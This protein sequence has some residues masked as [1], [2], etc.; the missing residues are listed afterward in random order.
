MLNQI[1]YCKFVSEMLSIT[2]GLGDPGFRG[3]GK[4][5]M[6]DLIDHTGTGGTEGGI[7]QADEFSDDSNASDLD[8]SSSEENIFPNEHDSDKGKRNQ[9]HSRKDSKSSPKISVNSALK[10][11]QKLFLMMKDK[12]KRQKIPSHLERLLTPFTADKLVKADPFHKQNDG[13]SDEDDDEERD[14]SEIREQ[15][16]KQKERAKKVAIEHQ[17]EIVD[18]FDCVQKPQN[19]QVSTYLEKQWAEIPI[20]KS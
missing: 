2:Q 3:Q 16:E 13:K 18:N 5:F 6:D 8:V 1:R 19:N 4:R 17:S 12:K 14:S 11:H 10:L 7:E 15:L 9:N 20:F